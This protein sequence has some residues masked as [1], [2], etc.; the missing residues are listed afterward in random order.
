MVLIK[1]TKSGQY[2]VYSKGDNYEILQSSEELKTMYSAF[3]HIKAMMKCWGGERV[4]VKYGIF[5][6][7]VTVDTLYST[8]KLNIL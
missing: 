8:F 3:K 7:F 4:K 2:R 1:K 6:S 5:S